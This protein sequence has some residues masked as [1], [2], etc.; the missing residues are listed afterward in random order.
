MG[1][2]TPVCTPLVLSPLLL[3]LVIIEPSRVSCDQLRKEE[4][5]TDGDSV[6]VVANERS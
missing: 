6:N 1:C 4:G 2:C 3:I 5:T